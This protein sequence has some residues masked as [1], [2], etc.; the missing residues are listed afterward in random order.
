[1][2]N[3]I[4][5]KK[6]C[7]KCE[8]LDSTVEVNQWRENAT[9]DKSFFSIRSPVSPVFFLPVALSFLFQSFSYKSVLL[10]GAGYQGNQLVGN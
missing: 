8:H 2:N 10:T 3:K 1:M 9:I 5:K 4:E 7:V 6:N